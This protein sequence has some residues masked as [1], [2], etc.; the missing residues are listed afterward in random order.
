[1][2]TTESFDGSLALESF[3]SPVKDNKSASNLD[4]LASLELSDLSRNET[5]LRNK[6][7]LA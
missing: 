3:I 6:I 1:M 2:K 7:H 5:L 4:T